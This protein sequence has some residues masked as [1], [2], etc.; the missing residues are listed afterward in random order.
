MEPNSI[1]S[2]IL[3]DVAFGAVDIG[4]AHWLPPHWIPYTDEFDYLLV[5][6]DADAA[7]DLA[8]Q[9]S[10]RTQNPQRFRILKA[11]LSGTGGPRAFFR[12]N[13]PT[14]SSLLKPAIDE[15][16]PAVFFSYPK[17]DNP[18]Y[19][20]PVHESVIETITLKNAL[21]QAR[22]PG[23]HMIKL[24]TQGTELEIV[25][26]LSERLSETVLVQMETGDHDHYV[27]QPGLGETI[28]TMKRH[29]F[30]LLDLQ[31]ARSE[32][33]FRG[34]NVGPT[35]YGESL[36]ASPQTTIDRAFVP[37]LHEVDAVFIR[38]PMVTAKAGD[39]IG[40]RRIIAAMCVYRL[41]GEA[42]QLTGIGELMKLWDGLEARRYRRDIKR[43]HQLIKKSLEAGYRI[44]WENA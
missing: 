26:G 38:D 40:L 44:H 30:R 35:S 24:D 27:D 22:F 17:I 37:R 12:L 41:F 16:D 31:L 19:V 39:A 6:P 2:S 4:A 21:E 10:R 9:A 15:N 32:M 3:K 14:G 43:S 33:V 25:E 36:F 42:F 20:F 29:G 8:I 28:T 34:A 5:E 18:S 11:A 23:A 1:F 13:C 7:K